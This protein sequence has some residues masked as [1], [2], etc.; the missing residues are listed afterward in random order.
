MFFLI[1]YARLTLKT[2][3]SPFEV[4]TRLRDN[5][6]SRAIGM[7]IKAYFRLSEHKPFEGKVANGTFNIN[8]IIHY[9][10]SWLPYLKGKIEQDLDT[11]QIIFT[12]TPPLFSM[13]ITVLAIFLV[14]FAI[15]MAII[16]E[17]PNSLTGFLGP[18]FIALLFVLFFY[19]VSIAFFNYE[20]RKSLKILKE[21]TE[22]IDSPI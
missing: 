19:V 1:P 4:E 14:P 2:Y 6:Q 15:L 20:I 12:A 16:Q 17:S 21:I 11:T 8:R 7:R 22:A 13:V 10:N 9:R 3:L 5:V 18:V